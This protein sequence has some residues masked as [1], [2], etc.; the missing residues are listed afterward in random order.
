MWQP[1]EVNRS[2]SWMNLKISREAFLKKLRIYFDS[3]NNIPG[4][5]M[6]IASCV[7]CYQARYVIGISDIVIRICISFN[8]NR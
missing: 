1:P 6:R 7:D 2:R 4:L 8:W 5:V 3:V